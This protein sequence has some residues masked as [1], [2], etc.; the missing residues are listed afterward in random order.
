MYQAACSIV[1][2]SSDTFTLTTPI[3]DF[4]EYHEVVNFG[5]KG[6]ESFST[7][8]ALALAI[9]SIGYDQSVKFFA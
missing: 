6:T 3:S 2:I 1:R 7:V 9:Q 8:P 4:G 5:F